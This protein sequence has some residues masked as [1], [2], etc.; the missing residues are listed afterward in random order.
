MNIEEFIGHF[1]ITNS[2]GS[3]FQ[4]QCPAHADAR[5]SLSITESGQKI[6]VKCFAGCTAESILKAVG[7]KMSDL[8]NGAGSDRVVATYDYCDETS[9]ILFRIVRTE[10]KKFIAERY[11]NGVFIRGINGVRRVPYNLPAVIKAKTVVIVEGEKDVETLRAIGIVAATNPFGAGKWDPS[12]NKHFQDKHV[13]V[14]GDN[15]P[16]GRAHAFNIATELLPVAKSVRIVALPVPEKGDVTDYLETHTKE[17]LL[18]LT[19][20]TKPFTA[21]ESSKSTKPSAWDKAKSA[22]ELLAE[23]DLAITGL[24]KDLIV[25]GAITLMAAPRGLGKSLVAQSAGVSIALGR[26]FRGGKTTPLRVLLVDRDNPRKVVKDRLR[27][28]GAA[29]AINLK[30]LTREDAPDLQDKKSWESFPVSDYDVVL[31]DS[32]GSFTEGVTEREGKETTLI[33]AT[34]LDLIH[35]GPAVLL[36]ANCTKDALS[37]KGRGEWM[38]RVDIVYEVRDATGFTPSGKK[39]WWLE[40]PAA[41]EA[42][43]ADRASRR[44]NRSD[45]RLGFIPSK[46]R[47]GAQPDPFCIELRLPKDEPWT[48]DD[49]TADLVAAG[50]NTIKEAAAKKEAQEKAAVDSLLE[51]VTTRFAANDPVLKT[52]AQNYIHEME[53]SRDRAR[54]LVAINIGVLWNIVDVRG[55]GSPKALIPLP[56]TNPPRKQPHER[57]SAAGRSGRGPQKC[58]PCNSSADN[59]F[60]ESPFLLRTG[61]DSGVVDEGGFDW[62]AGMQ[63]EPVTLPAALDRFTE[64]VLFNFEFY[65]PDGANPSP[66][67]LVGYEIRSGAAIRLLRP[68]FPSTPPFGIGSS[69]LWVAYSGA[70]DLRCCLAIGWPL[71]ENFID[72]GVEGKLQTNNPGPDRGIPKLFECCDRFGIGHA[73]PDE[74]KKLNKYFGKAEVLSDDDKLR[75]LPHCENNV[76]VLPEL[77]SKLSPE[78]DTD[79][80]LGRGE[81]VKQIAVIE[82]RGISI[83]GQDYKNIA[84]N[85]EQIKRDFIDQSTVGAE[86]YTNGH[87]DFKK[88][89]IWIEKND[90]DPDSWKRT[91][92][93]RLCTEEDYLADVANVVPVVKPFLDLVL[94]LKDFKKIPFGIGSD[95]RSHADQIPFGTITGRNAASKYVLT[96]SRWWRWVIQAPEGSALIYCDYEAMEYA[97]AAFLSGDK[98]MSANY[99]G[100]DIHAGVAKQLGI[101]RNSAKT[102]NFAMQYGGGPKGL[103]ESLGIP[104]SDAQEIYHQHKSTYSRYWKWSDDFV[105]TLKS[106][107]VYVLPDGWALRFDA[108]KNGDGLLSARN[109]PVQASAGA[110]FRRSVIETA[111]ADIE[112][113]G[114]LHDALLMQAPVADAERVSAAAS[115]IMR[116]VSKHFLGKEIRVS[117]KIYLDRFEDKDGAGDWKRISKILK[118]Y[119]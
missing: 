21:E 94:A 79:Q 48:L 25:P 68:D 34:V 69:A 45:Y 7:L 1:N 29:D 114:T 30:V 109:F 11:E 6:L 62:A 52:E 86:L 40:L 9:A 35:R 111:K 116:G 91:P 56:L 28:F 70:S 75:V 84:A 115:K 97:V 36:L 54:E 77:L 119:K 32:L 60:C 108:N 61:F 74:K 101:D 26:E 110:I 117:S 81:Y 49:V 90:I 53:I 112:T 15:D 95:G 80:A 113:V 37:V 23:E 20:A 63:H 55:K 50:E 76:V 51:T 65:C 22:P 73:D 66:H 93:G 24:A 39:D 46:F 104:I 42:A 64:I 31:I 19:K 98:N 47:L 72:L 58:D 102:V 85:R 96:A 4:A 41:G 57:K 105:E 8:F 92:A 59:D 107:G 44:K 18:T 106:T 88:L 3:D 2:S 87:F 17:D 71:P 118:K 16:P 43:W 100:G 67:C 12:F 82:H 10:S 78:M 38:D 33:L 13:A 27:G 14:L 99:L 5:P 103:S 83:V 89:L